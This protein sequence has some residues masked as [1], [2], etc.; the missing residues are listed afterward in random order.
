MKSNVFHRRTSYS[1]SNL[2]L[3]CSTY[4]ASSQNSPLTTGMTAMLKAAPFDRLVSCFRLNHRLNVSRRYLK[5]TLRLLHEFLN[6]YFPILC[7]F[8]SAAASAMSGEVGLR[9]R[10]GKSTTTYLS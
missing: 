7:L 9:R 4:V 2:S 1:F 5:Q 6:S 10:K 3:L 8:V